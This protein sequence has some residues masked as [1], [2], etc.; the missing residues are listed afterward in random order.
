MG[1][2]PFSHLS[3]SITNLVN[4]KNSSDLDLRPGP[5]LKSGE[6]SVAR[7]AISEKIVVT[8]LKRLKK[9]ITY[10]EPDPRSRCAAAFR[11]IG[12]V[13]FARVG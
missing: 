1:K 2:V 3:I 6:F 13:A 9:W 8:C 5:E 11:R 7:M 12:A 4:F 10:W